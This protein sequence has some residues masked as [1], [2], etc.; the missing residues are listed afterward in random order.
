MDSIVLHKQFKSRFKPKTKNKSKWEI[1]MSTKREL[2]LKAF[3][4]EE[5]ERIPV[6]FWHH[7]LDESEFVSGVENPGKYFESF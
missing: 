5:V 2:V 7:Y 1:I 6:G 3:H 4:N